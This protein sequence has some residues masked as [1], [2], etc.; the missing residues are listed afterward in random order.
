MSHDENREANH[1]S[2]GGNAKYLYCFLALCVL[3]AAS[4]FTYSDAW[5][6]K[7]TPQIGWAFMMAVSCTKAA[8]V[9]L[10]FMHLWWEASWKFVLT[11]PC[12]F[13]S[14]YLLCM[15]IPDVGFRNDGATRERL[16]HMSEQRLHPD[17][18]S[19]DTEHSEHSKT[20]EP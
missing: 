4:F 12:V 15:L 5:P 8:L 11:V 7:E 18:I 19:D 9:I 17:Y 16:L 2:H 6:F 14:V 20:L 1:E 13:L 3:T 10:V